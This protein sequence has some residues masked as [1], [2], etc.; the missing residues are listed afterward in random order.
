MGGRDFCPEIPEVASCDKEYRG[1]WDLGTSGVGIQRRQHF[2][3]RSCEVPKLGT[4]DMWQNHKVGPGDRQVDTCRLVKGV[5]TPLTSR[6]S[7]IHE[8]REREFN[9]ST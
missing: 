8:I 6:V 1:V 9:P 2:G 4:R 7:R 5:N 3:K